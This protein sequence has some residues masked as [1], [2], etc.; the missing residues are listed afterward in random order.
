MRP[1]MVDRVENVAGDTV[2]KYMPEAYGPLMSAKEAETLTGFM[3]EVVNSGTASALR[4]DA[5]TVAGKDVYKR[6][7]LLYAGFGRCHCSGFRCF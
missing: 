2:K 6:Q 7:A 1:Y 5:Y 4:T 3:K